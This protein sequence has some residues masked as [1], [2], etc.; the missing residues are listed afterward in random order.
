KIVAQAIPYIQQMPESRKAAG[1]W[2]FNQ[3][4]SAFLQAVRQLFESHPLRDEHFWLMGPLPAIQ[5]KRGGR[6]RWQLLLQ[7][8]SRSQLQKIVAQAI[9]Y[10]Q[11]MP[12]SRKVRWNVDVD[13]TD[14]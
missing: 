11:Q 5:A 1:M 6:F 8:P 7:H 4:A 12:E 13:P 10:I 9:P 2:M 14:G 3:R